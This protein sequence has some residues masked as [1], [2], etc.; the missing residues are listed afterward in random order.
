MRPIRVGLVAA[1]LFTGVL[2]SPVLAGASDRGKVQ[3]PPE[4]V[5]LKDSRLKF[6]IND[7][8]GDGGVQAFIDGDG[9]RWISIFDPSGRKIFTAT[10]KGIM[11]E[12]GGTELFLES[13]E[14]PFSELPMSELLERF[15]EG[16][17]RFY[18]RGIEGE[19]FVGSA[20]LS[21]NIPSGPV[22]VSPI[23]GDAL[24]DPGNTVVEWEAVIP[25]NGSPIV[26]YQVLV[27]QPDTGLAGLPKVVLDV[28]M[29]P[30]AMTMEVPEGFLQPGTEY[31]WEV[32]A[33]EASGNQTLSSSFFTTTD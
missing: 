32:L 30:T 33:I 5:E 25:P 6:E 2:S 14:P 1:V 20:N 23:E 19:T 3:G 29:P 8:D 9:W 11:A 17:Y 26:G 18:G 12:Q 10:T 27:V 15:P 31:E 22:L 13:A 16:E 28:M 21:H 7:T 4:V 24:Q